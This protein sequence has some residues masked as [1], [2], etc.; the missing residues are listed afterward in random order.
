[1]SAV[2]NNK[3]YVV[4][5]CNGEECIEDDAPRLYRYDP[6]TD[7]W[8]SLPPPPASHTR[9]AAGF[10]GGKLYVTGGV[11]GGDT[12]QVDVYDPATNQWSKGTPF[13]IRRWDMA[14][15]AYNSKLYLIGGY[16]ENSDGS[17]TV[18]RAT[19]IYDPA[20]NRWTTG[21]ALPT[22]RREIAAARVVLNGSPRIEVVGGPAPGNNLSYQP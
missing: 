19:N 11:G 4:T 12:R 9:G 22:A 5:S 3:L 7:T 20:T 16:R 8:A 18:V 13:G 1:M 6:A 2:S 14:G 21:A 10:I 15:L 17:A